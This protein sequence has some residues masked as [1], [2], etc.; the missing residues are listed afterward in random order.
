MFCLWFVMCMPDPF[1]VRTHEISIKI[2]FISHHIPIY[3][4]HAQHIFYYNGSFRD[5]LHID[6][7][8]GYPLYECG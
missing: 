3:N 1:E 7:S 6:S 8:V 5:C 2:Y 4:F